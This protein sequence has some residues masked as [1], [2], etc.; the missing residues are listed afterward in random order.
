MFEPE[1]MEYFQREAPFSYYC[2]LFLQFLI[3]V[4]SY[5]S[6]LV[7]LIVVAAP[8]F[9]IYFGVK[10]I[11]IK[12]IEDKQHKKIRKEKEKHQETHQKLYFDHLDRNIK[13]KKKHK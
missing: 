3:T 13:K 12:F 1:W 7:L 5:F 6:Y 10:A 11:K 4:L 9:M 8:I 2:I